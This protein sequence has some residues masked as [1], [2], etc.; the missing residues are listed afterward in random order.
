MI[1]NVEIK[2]RSPFV[3]G[4]SFGEVGAYERIDGVA[5]GLLDPAHPAQPGDRAPGPGA[6]KYGWVGGVS[7]P[8]LC[9]CGRWMRR[10]ATGGCY[11][12]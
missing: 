10:G 1:V 6:R 9:C 3:G 2:H 5:T 12:R 8:I 7:S 4:A 11:M